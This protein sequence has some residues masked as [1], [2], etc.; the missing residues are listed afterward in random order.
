MNFQGTSLANNL[1]GCNP[2][3][4]LE[5]P[6]EDKRWP[7]GLQLPHYLDISLR[8]PSCILGSFYHIRIQHHPSNAL[9]SSCFSLNSHPQSHLASPLP[10]PF[11]CSTC[12]LSTH[13][14]FSISLNLLAN[15]LFSYSS[16]LTLDVQF[17]SEKCPVGACVLAIS[18]FKFRFLSY[19]YMNI[20]LY[21]NVYIKLYICIYL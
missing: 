18:W 14:M 2:R 15:N 13:K 3:A 20:K 12:P 8:L 10:L 17:G 1:I 9:N 4:V 5:A 21:I 7:L 19:I 6:I 16:F 11:P